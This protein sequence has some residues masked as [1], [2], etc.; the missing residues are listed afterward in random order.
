MDVNEFRCQT[1]IDKTLI[2]NKYMKYVAGIKQPDLVSEICVQIPAFCDPV[3]LSTITSLHH[4]A[5][6]PDRIHFAVCFQDD[7]RNVLDV[8]KSMPNCK[9][10]HFPK[11]DAP[12]LCAA[13]Y[14]CNK[15]IENEPYVMHIDSHM[16]VAKYWDVALI[17]MW[18]ACQDEKAII[19]GYPLDYTKYS[20]CDPDDTV[21]TEQVHDCASA[22]GVVS[23]IDINGNVRFR[24]L[25]LHLENINHRGLFIS[26]GFL[27]AK[28]ELDRECPSD[29]DMFF[30]A[31]EIMM[32]VRYWS[33]GYNI[34]HPAYMPVW[35]LYGERQ[36]TES[37]P[38]ERFNTKND[39]YLCKRETE[40][41]RIRSMLK[42]IDD[43]IDFGRF[44]LGDKRSLA[45]FIKTS[46]I[47]FAHH[48]V[49]G[50]AKS[51]N[52][53]MDENER[54]ASDKQWYYYDMSTE[55]ADKREHVCDSMELDK[56]DGTQNHKTICVQIPSYKDPQIIRTVRSLLYQAD[57]PERVHIVI[58]LQDDDAEIIKELS[59]IQNVRFHQVDPEKARGTGTARLAC[60][61]MYNHEDYVLITDAHMLAIKHWDTMLIRQLLDTHDE[62]A[63]ISCQ[64]PDFGVCR[65]K[66]FWRGCFDMP[67]AMCAAGIDSFT[68]SIGSMPSLL[69][70]NHFALYLQEKW[71]KSREF[72][73]YVKGFCITGTYTFT[74]GKFNRQVPFSQDAV[75][76]GDE[77]ITSVMAYT[78][79]FHVYTYRQG[80]L[81]HDALTKRPL[82]KVRLNDYIREQQ[83]MYD[84]V[85]TGH[86]GNLSLGSVHTIDDLT[87]YLGV[88]FKNRMIYKRAYTCEPGE[89]DTDT[90]SIGSH[91]LCEVNDSV[92]KTKIHLIAVFSKQTFYN[93][94]M[95]P[96]DKIAEFKDSFLKTACRPDNVELHAI[97]V[98]DGRTYGYHV[99]Q[100]M[101][102]I[103][104]NDDDILLFVD[105]AVRF[106][107]K[108]DDF[109]VRSFDGLNAA[110]VWSTNTYANVR[111]TAYE[112]P[113][114]KIDY[115]FCKPEVTVS[116]L[117]KSGSSHIKPVIL[118]GV[119]AMRCQ[120]YRQVPFDPD[121]SYD[122]HVDTY[123]LRLYTHGYDIYYDKMSH[124]YRTHIVKSLDGITKS[125]T[126][127]KNCLFG[128]LYEDYD[129]DWKTYPYGHG[130]ARSLISWYRQ[131]GFVD[132]NRKSHGTAEF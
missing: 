81:L 42:L 87:K 46:G 99:N 50:V 69:Y 47:D 14:E 66:D 65:N 125:D 95:S 111:N 102:T 107:V 59:E 112:N 29:P 6:N 26:G 75:Y 110:S 28:A 127:I 1:L 98:D 93:K 76:R 54:P 3:L 119:V 37:K 101:D 43:P 10:R 45:S 48:A 82:R 108:W 89:V 60:Q 5:A 132:P 55:P 33:H 115:D 44:G 17:D 126:H 78:H 67:Y 21:F 103:N 41:R 8:L 118:H 4:N 100:L 124:M 77:C 40:E 34:Y 84:L 9:V 123:S 35:H 122:D 106:L 117:Y 12:G 92:C 64:A 114:I 58:C 25:N 70:N 131:F 27:F 96:E 61:L 88:D 97:C 116:K 129:S 74:F 24:G 83:V 52:F 51:G 18:N 22:I 109:L 57:Y 62:N 86:S 71:Q 91:M 31:D 120:T 30:I 80:Y 128:S 63:I 11:I 53:F 68:D 79:G 20:D 39:N 16:R 104:A 56:D 15:M 73:T 32:D 38:V 72:D 49:L 23:N 130:T 105:G 2:E 85:M 113:V 121:I 36:T 13:R 7:D 90:E 19:S 94:N